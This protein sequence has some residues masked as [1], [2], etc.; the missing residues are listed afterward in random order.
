MFIRKRSFGAGAGVLGLAAL[1]LAGC[2]DHGPKTYPVKGTITYKGK[3]VP[4]GTVMFQPEN[5]PAATGDI[6]DG[7]YVLQTDKFNG[8]VLGKHKVTIIAFQD[9]AGRLPEERTPF[10]PP[11]IPDKYSTPDRS[12]LT[13]VVEAKENVFNF[14]LK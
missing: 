5:G 14:D 1:A 11:I 13:S 4:H 7:N 3:A 2:G 9:Q 8:A 6:K 12:G 10:P